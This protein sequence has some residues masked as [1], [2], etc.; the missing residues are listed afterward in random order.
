MSTNKIN[1]TDQA[2]WHAGEKY[3]E[4]LYLLSQDMLDCKKARD[5]EGMVDVF[6]EILIHTYAFIIPHMKKS[7]HSMFDNNDDIL[8]FMNNFKPD[9]TDTE[10]R[11]NS[12]IIRRMI[13]MLNVKRKR[14][15]ILF[16]LAGLHIPSKTNYDINDAVL[17]MRG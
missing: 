17:E 13:R 10:Q 5:I 16:A 7:D 14:L 8:E 15:S 4:F 12:Q 9:N 11:E 3:F 2:A 1:T 6:D